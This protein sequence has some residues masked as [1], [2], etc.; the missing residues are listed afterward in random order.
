MVKASKSKKRRIEEFDF[1]PGR[2][3]AGKYEVLSR[4][5]AGWEGEVFKVR[6][7]NMGIVRAAK[8][9]YPHRNPRDRNANFYAKKL[10][11][12]R[13][14]D[15]LIQYHTHETIRFKGT[16]VTFLVSDYVEGELLFELLK[17][18]P[19]RRLT[20]FEGLHL[21]HS[22][23]SGIECIHLLGDYHGDIHDENIIVNR[24]GLGFEVKL[25]DLFHWGA[26]KASNIHQ[27][28][29]DLI[30]VFYD[31]IGGAKRYARHPPVVKEI[32]CGLKRTLILQKFRTAGQLREHLE[33][34]EWD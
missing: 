11:K 7:I 6:E 1:Q 16:P 10:H 12:L 31:V 3:L 23:A 22:L 19:G 21:L 17:R 25:V 18:Q 15:V 8:F 33:N 4:L 14:C 24:Y 2:V 13:V 26:P 28:V 32:C 30:R 5:G 29:V 20:V 34:V 9:F 27:D